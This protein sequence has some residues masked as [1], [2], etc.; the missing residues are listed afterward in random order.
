MGGV[1]E[2]MIHSVQQTLRVRLKEQLIIDEVLSTAMGEVM[3]VPNSRSLTLKSD[4]PLDEQLLT[5][6]HLL[7][8]RPRSSL[9][10]GIFDKD[11]LY[12]RRAWKDS[13]GGKFN[14]GDARQTTREGRT[15][16]YSKHLHAQ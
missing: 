8:L 14:R 11:D 12:C 9:P 6:N 16:D 3:N 10:P 7:Y 15:Y 2:P 13:L 4:G 5:A 1:W